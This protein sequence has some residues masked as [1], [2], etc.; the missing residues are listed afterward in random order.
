VIASAGANG[1]ALAAVIVTRNNPNV[2]VGPLPVEI[3]GSLGFALLA[4]VLFVR[5]VGATLVVAFLSSILTQKVVW[6]FQVKNRPPQNVAPSTVAHG[7]P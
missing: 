2:L 6:F 3:I 7:E 5:K 4:V 1:M